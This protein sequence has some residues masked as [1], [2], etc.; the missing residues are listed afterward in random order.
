[1]LLICKSLSWKS[2]CLLLTATRNAFFFFFFFSNR[3]DAYSRTSGLQD[4]RRM[5]ALDFAGLQEKRRWSWEDGLRGG[6]LASLCL[7]AV[8]AC[9]REGEASWEL[10]PQEFQAD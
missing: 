9:D 6:L 5:G 7:Q 10:Q 3:E 4:W 8:G 2:S 1:M